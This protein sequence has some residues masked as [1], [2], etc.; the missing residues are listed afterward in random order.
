MEYRVWANII[1]LPKFERT[2][3]IHMEEKM[4]VRG[5]KMPVPVLYQVRGSFFHITTEHP[6]DGIPPETTLP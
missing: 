5:I 1:R 3:P 6:A 4:C 2:L